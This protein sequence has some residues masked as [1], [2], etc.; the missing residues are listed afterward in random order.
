[1]GLDGTVRTRRGRRDL[2]FG[3]VGLDGVDGEAP[4]ARNVNC[5]LLGAFAAARD[6]KRN[7]PE[8]I[9]SDMLACCSRSRPTG[10]LA[11]AAGRA[12]TVAVAETA[13]VEEEAARAG[14]SEPTDRKDRPASHLGRRMH[15]P[16][17]A[18]IFWRWRG[19]RSAAPRG[20]V[21]Q[22]AATSPSIRPSGAGRANAVSG[23]GFAAAG[24][25][26]PTSPGRGFHGPWSR[27]APRRS[28]VLARQSQRP[29]AR[30]RPD[31][32]RHEDRATQTSD[33]VVRLCWLH[34]TTGRQLLTWPL[35]LAAP[36]RRCSSSLHRTSR[37]E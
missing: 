12:R 26:A 19:T 34:G 37:S 29:A 3:D 21:A 10:P 17:K 33:G 14:T 13:L 8:R 22:G 16:W 9:S 2:E 11:P 23:F 20:L 4:T 36:L 15:P 7:L 6:E 35:Q 24:R 32:R 31:R 18:D 27:K 25:A 1:V 28:G 30:F 5:F